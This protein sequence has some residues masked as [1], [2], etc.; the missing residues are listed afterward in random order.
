MLNENV[1]Q[2]CKNINC[3]YKTVNMH[4]IPLKNSELNL[5]NLKKYTKYNK[6]Y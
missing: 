2:L 5:L 4:K 3:A 6:G 1:F